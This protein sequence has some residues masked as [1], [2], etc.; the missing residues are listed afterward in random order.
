[1]SRRLAPDVVLAAVGLLSVVTQ[2]AISPFAPLAC[3]VLAPVHGLC[4]ASILGM[5]HPMLSALLERLSALSAQRARI[6]TALLSMDPLV[7][8][9]MQLASSARWRTSLV[10]CSRGCT[11]LCDHSQSA[12]SHRARWRRRPHRRTPSC[13]RRPPRPPLAGP[14]RTRPLPPPPSACSSMRRLA[15]VYHR[16]DCSGGAGGVWAPRVACSCSSRGHRCQPTPT[17]S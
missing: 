6:D 9:A 8:A 17:G 7:Q 1:M 2:C 11:T 10:A 5:L 3:A 12:G 15:S 13:H 16:P 4:C 14:V